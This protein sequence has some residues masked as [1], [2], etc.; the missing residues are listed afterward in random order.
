[1]N[2]SH[3]QNT[4]LVIFDFDGTIADTSEGIIDAH[5]FTLNYM[6]QS[7]PSEELLRNIIGGN[8][9]TTYTD[10]FGFGEEE[11]LLAVNIYR[12]RYEE[13]GIHK[14]NIY[15]GFEKMLKTIKDHKI[16]IGVATLKA[17]RFAN[18]MLQEM[19]VLSYFDAVCGIQLS[20]DLTK[21]EL[22]DKCIEKCGGCA[23]GTILVGDTMNDWNG[24]REAGVSFVGVTYGFGFKEGN[25]YDFPTIKSPMELC[26]LIK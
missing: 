4:E 23:E 17:E 7:V 14:A 10:V 18:L 8:L 6:H 11:A 5:K 13:V 15:S 25:T 12:K 21:A 1:M 9:F 26:H 2:L 16:R 22:V 24:A 19:N 3:L 20:D